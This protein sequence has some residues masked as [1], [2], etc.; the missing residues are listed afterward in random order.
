M[1][2]KGDNVLE[3]YV[4]TNRCHNIALIILLLSIPIH[5]LLA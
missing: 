3:I 2:A 1:Q 5:V 4:N